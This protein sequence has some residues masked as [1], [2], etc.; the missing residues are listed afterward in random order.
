MLVNNRWAR[1]SGH[2]NEKT[3]SI[4]YREDWQQAKDSGLYEICIQIAWYAQTVDDSNGYPIISEQ[5]K[6]LTFTEQLQSKVEKD[7]GSVISMMITHDGVNQWIIYSQDLDAFKEGL[8]GVPVG[9]ELYPIEVVADD[10]PDWH[11]FVQV[12]NSIDKG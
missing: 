7:E 11:T 8:E 6:I 3:I 9:E 1:A 5:A 10:D 2:L 4:Q 12:Y